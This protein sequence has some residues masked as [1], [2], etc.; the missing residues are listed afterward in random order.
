[1]QAVIFSIRSYQIPTAVGVL[2]TTG[3]NCSVLD[4]F[5]YGF[6]SRKYALC[7]AYS[8]M[9]LYGMTYSG[10]DFFP[11]LKEPTE[12]FAAESHR[13]LLSLGFE[14][15]VGDFWQDDRESC[16]PPESDFLPKPQVGDTPDKMPDITAL[17]PYARDHRYCK[18]LIARLTESKVAGQ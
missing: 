8:A 3:Y 2:L 15:Q 1:M 5:K 18:W 7:T 9:D 14:P 4:I 10:C 13:R 6:L 16:E 12:D 11:E 17:W